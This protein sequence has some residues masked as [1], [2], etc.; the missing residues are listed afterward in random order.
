MQT[1]VKEIND[2]GAALRELVADGHVIEQ[3]KGQRKDCNGPLLM[4]VANETK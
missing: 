1:S 3:K 4:R 2:E